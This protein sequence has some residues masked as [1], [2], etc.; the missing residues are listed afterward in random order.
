MALKL[1]RVNGRH[2]AAL[3]G[4]AVRVRG[5]VTP[6]VAGE[7]VTVRFFRGERK[8]RAKEVTVQPG[9]EGAGQFVLSHTERGAGR[10]VVRATHAATSRQATIVAK[11]V[12]YDVLPPR[13]SPGSR[14]AGVRMLQRRL[15]RHGYVVGRRGVYDGRTARAVVAFHKVTG[16]ART[17]T[18]SS[19]TMRRLARGGGRF[20]VRFP[21]SGRHLEADISRQV[22]ALI[23][24]DGKVERIYPTSSGKPSTPTILGS[25]RVYRKDFGTN[26]LGMVHSVYFRGGYALHGYK[27]VPTVGASAGCLRVPTPDAL[28]IFRWMKHGTRVHTYR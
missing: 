15:A 5:T 19:A 4:T 10:V 3:S 9:P 14:G 16:M 18:A 6:F 22:I 2:G 13:A 21:R 24:A 25:Y 20:R 7:K 17:S 23:G 12:G 28:S 26:S 1:E 27:S 11:G 8:L